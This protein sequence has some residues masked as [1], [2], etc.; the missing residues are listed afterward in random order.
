[1]SAAVL[2]STIG[3]AMRFDYAHA[4]FSASSEV[5]LAL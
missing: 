4:L 5:P 2:P 3:V 1:M